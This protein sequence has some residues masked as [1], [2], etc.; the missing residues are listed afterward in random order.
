M[1]YVRFQAIQR[2]VDFG[3]ECLKRLR[4]FAHVAGTDLRLVVDDFYDA[5]RRDPNAES[6]LTGGAA[7]VERLKTTH[8]QWLT[9]LLEGPRDEAY[10]AS[11]SRIGRVHVR[12]NLSQEYMLTAVNRVRV[13]LHRVAT[14][15]LVPDELPGTMDA[16]DRALD[17][18]LALML[19]TYREDS[20]TR[21]DA[22]ARLAAVGQVAAS[23]GHELRNPLGVA[24]SS[25]FLIRQ[26]LDKLGLADVVL[27]KHVGRLEAQLRACSETITSMLEMARDAPLHRSEFPL[28]TAVQECLHMLRTDDV[29]V[30]IDVDE[31]TQVFADREQ[32]T[33][34]IGN[35][36]RNAVEAVEFA[37]TKRVTV[38]A[39]EIRGGVEF[40]IED[41][42]AGVE[43]TNR[44]RIFDALF[45]TR[46]RGT[47]LGLALSK[48]IVDRHG[49]EISLLPNGDA[50]ARFRVWLPSPSRHVHDSHAG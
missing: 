4:E 8:H 49:G 7:Q 16:I 48:N 36:L 23:I 50:G 26:R 5:I 38:T 45:T 9:A 44:P 37:T 30:R 14:A 43:E 28:V 12:I 1:D 41:S 24:G 19:D 6:V 10:L 2:Y 22:S 13:G 31:A 34:V 32:L 35:L 20:L 33:S 11:R 42:G 47:G 15:R 27:D 18:D 21:V 3:L 46:P 39:A 40:I 29:V 17:V 25:L